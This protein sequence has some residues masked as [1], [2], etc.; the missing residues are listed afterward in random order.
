MNFLKIHM[1]REDT[2]LAMKSSDKLKYSHVKRKEMKNCKRSSYTILKDLSN[3]RITNF[4]SYE[5]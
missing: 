3:K 4:V 1:H 5:L 2:L